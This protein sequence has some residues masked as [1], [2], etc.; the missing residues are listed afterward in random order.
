MSDLRMIIA[1]NLTKLRKASNLTQLELAEK[2]NY[3]DKAVSKWEHGDTMPDIETLKTIADLYGVTVDS[4][5]EEGPVE[6]KIDIKAE[7]RNSS[8]KV[9]ITLLA[10]TLIWFAAIFLYVE[11]KV[12]SDLN[13]WTI[14]VWA[15]P[16]SCIVLLVFNSI[17]GKKKLAYLI[18]SILLWSTL[19][20]IHLQF[21]K[22]ELWL[23]YFIGIPA[24]IAVILSSQL[25]HHSK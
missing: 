23:I 19:C 21:L 14:F 25:R 16:A 18:I 7:K 3:S 24:Q 13:I 6:D 11:F 8:N 2:L 22:Y 17:W 10:C 12:V 15:V 5:L 1:E 20:S 4:I 9:I